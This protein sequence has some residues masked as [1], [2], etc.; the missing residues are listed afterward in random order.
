MSKSI[1]GEKSF[2]FAVD[3]TLFHNT[4]KQE[5]V[6]VIPNQFL[7]SATSIGANVQEALGSQT[8]K[9]FHSKLSIARKEARE[10]FYWLRLLNET[11]TIDQDSVSPLIEQS[12]ELVRMLTA[13]TKTLDKKLN[14]KKS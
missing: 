1:I 14:G 13:A 3:A 8:E 7:R 9:E 2:K 4:L 11:T 5:K 6:V 10:A 12:E